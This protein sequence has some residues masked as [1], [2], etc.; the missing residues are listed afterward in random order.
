[1][2]SIPT[3]YQQEPIP[4]MINCRQSFQPI[5]MAQQYNDHSI[6][7]SNAFKN[8]RIGPQ[9]SDYNMSYQSNNSHRAPSSIQSTKGLIQPSRI[10]SL[11]QPIVDGIYPYNSNQSYYPQNK[12]T[13]NA[14]SDEY[15]GKNKTSTSFCWQLTCFG[16]TRLT[17]GILFGTMILLMAISIGGLVV[18]IILYV[19]DQ[20]TNSQW[21]IL[22][23]VVSCVLLITIIV[24]LCIF[25]YCYKNGRIG[26]SDDKSTLE[27]R[28]YNQ[29]NYFVKR[30]YFNR[31]YDM[32]SL[33]YGTNQNASP[34]STNEDIIQVEDKQ[35]NTEI[36]MA[37]LRP[38]DC[39]R[40][41]WPGK[42]A[43]GGISYRSFEKPIM[44][45]RFIQT[46]SNEDDQTVPQGNIN[47]MNIPP[48]TIIR[49]PGRSQPHRHGEYSSRFNETI[50]SRPIGRLI[51]DYVEHPQLQKNV[52][53]RLDDR[54]KIQI[55]NNVSVKRI[56]TFEEPNITDEFTTD[57]FFYQ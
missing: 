19:Q 5:P 44:T 45:H 30:N 57:H 7:Y 39:Q 53:E 26:N 1:M 54:R 38:R 36:T 31:S 17:A 37:P 10:H 40:G 49:L 24:T 2:M 41:V 20:S 25:I 3:S 9:Q 16:L 28:E 13:E 15:H 18:S 47:L 32:S 55:F 21:K 46:S 56:E 33:P 42:N 34:F 6:G 29:E 12:Y 8:N 11:K 35:T 48:R 27:T 51:E 52:I 23:I 14:V 43:Y 50:P 4:I 22:G